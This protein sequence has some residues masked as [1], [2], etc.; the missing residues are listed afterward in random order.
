[1]YLFG[2]NNFIEEVQTRFMVIS[3]LKSIIY[4]NDNIVV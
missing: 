2:E 1:M 3:Y 4:Q